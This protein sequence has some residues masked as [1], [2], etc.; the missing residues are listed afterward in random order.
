MTKVANCSV[1]IYE[2]LHT[3]LLKMTLLGS[4]KPCTAPMNFSKAA[5]ASTGDRLNHLKKRVE[6]Q[7]DQAKTY[8][9][10]CQEKIETNQEAIEKLRSEISEARTFIR[11]AKTNEC[12]MRQALCD[13]H[14]GSSIFQEREPRDVNEN[15]EY[16]LGDLQNKLNKLKHERRIKKKHLQNLLNTLNEAV[17]DVAFLELE[18]PMGDAQCLFIENQ[19]CTNDKK[20]VEAEMIG[21]TYRHIRDKLSAECLSS[22]SVLDAVSK[23]IRCQKE[24]L[25]TYEQSV[26]EATK[27]KEMADTDLFKTEFDLHG[28]RRVQKREAAEFKKKT[29]EEKHEFT[30][31]WKT[32]QAHFA[33]QESMPL[34]HM[35]YHSRLSVSISTELHEAIGLFEHSEAELELLKTVTGSHTVP[36]V[37]DKFEQ[38]ES[39]HEYAKSSVNELEV[40]KSALLRRSEELNIIQ[41]SLQF[42]AETEQEV[43]L[44]TASGDSQA[45][46]RGRWNR[47][48][49]Y[50][51]VTQAL[52]RLRQLLG[53]LTT[54]FISSGLLPP[55]S[56]KHDSSDTAA[57]LRALL[58]STS[59]GVTALMSSLGPDP[60]RTQQ[61]AAAAATLLMTRSEQRV[62]R[63]RAQ[64]EPHDAVRDDIGYV[65]TDGD[66]TG[67]DTVPSRAALKRQAHLI[68]MTKQKSGSRGRKK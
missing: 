30:I 34:S 62:H 32:I 28:T 24:E 42:R 21:H 20:Y 10:D 37:A 55:Q 13:H 63:R 14:T 2:H 47:L 52:V 26:V 48:A 40:R 17:N 44:R 41:N 46:S 66:T 50:R 51:R 23:L 39:T 6:L 22:A 9:E 56:E 16:R 64:L 35:T 58:A 3:C 65:G 18:G 7:N 31:L 68:L 54:V 57:H 12:L 61:A 53:Y 29:E 33:A 36:E 4:I 5:K 11:S 67:D 43:L 60:E 38:Q 49:A 45:A 27:K 59:A 25:S 1:Q 8:A 15:V 19:I